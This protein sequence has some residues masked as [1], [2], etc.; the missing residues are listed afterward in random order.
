M[1]FRLARSGAADDVRA[2]DL[3]IA[4]KSGWRHSSGWVAMWGAPRDVRWHQS[5]GYKALPPLQYAKIDR[6][7][8]AR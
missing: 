5:D 6:K 7:L 4:F 8:T 1:G 2:R 3:N